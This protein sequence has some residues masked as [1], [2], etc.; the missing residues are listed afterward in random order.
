MPERIGQASLDLLARGGVQLLD[1]FAHLH[2]PLHSA[3]RIKQRGA[4][5]FGPLAIYF[6]K[7]D[8]VAARADANR[9]VAVLRFEVA[10][11]AAW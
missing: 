9:A 10:S 5:Q 7:F 1:R 11:A 4:G 3:Q 6:Q 8:P 2:Q